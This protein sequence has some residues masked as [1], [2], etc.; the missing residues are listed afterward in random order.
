MNDLTHD[1]SSLANLHLRGAVIGAAGGQPV[2]QR[3]PPAAPEEEPL[4]SLWDLREE[5]EF[6]P[7]VTNL[8]STI[9]RMTSQHFS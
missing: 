3:I 5:T 4:D 1:M 9:S 7:L 6:N 8:H 2:N